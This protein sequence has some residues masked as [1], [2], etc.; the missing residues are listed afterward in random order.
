MACLGLWVGGV[1]G[2]ASSQSA[3]KGDISSVKAE[4]RI[5][6]GGLTADEIQSQVM[7]FADTYLAYVRQG[8]EELMRGGLTPEER[9]RAYRG[10]LNTVYGAVL[11]AS[12]PNSL[13]AMM[14]MV[15]LVTLGRMLTED[16]WIPDVFGDRALP[17][18]KTL[19][20]AEAE[21]W[22]LAK[23]VLW[24]EQ[25]QELHDIIA[26]WRVD[27][28]DQIVISTIRLSELSQY[29]R[30]TADAGGKQRS[31]V[32]SFFYVDPLAN[33]DPATRE[34]KR[35]RELTERVFYYS[36]R[37][38]LL[39]NWMM[40]SL[41]YDLAASAEMQQLMANTTQVADVSERFVAEIEGFPDV[42]ARERKAAITQMA[43]NITVEREAA[44][45]QFMAGIADE[46][47]AFMDDLQAEED[48]LRGA[49]ADLKLTIDA[50]T[51]LSS[52]LDITVASLDKFVAQFESD[53]DEP[54]GEPFDI[55]DYRQTA[56]ELTQAARQLDELV[57]SVDQLLVTARPGEDESSFMAAIEVAETSGARL[58]DVAFKRAL[59]IVAALV[60]G[61]VVV[62]LVWRLLPR[63]APR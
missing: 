56:I 54:R 16:Y 52:S 13:V 44:I 33:L 9:A 35:A 26:Q 27:H 57:A 31:S 42:I 3:A 11:I 30:K 50:G 61:S 43:G 41:Y 4:Q 46:R 23:L 7:G 53:P 17:V 21:I 2:C 12:G 20:T 34:I 48:R 40:R 38:P 45:D 14:D 55:N 22:E 6:P 36:E 37:V 47:K 24:P 28:P 10:Q 63:G 8:V 18:L 5:G 32:F 62:V 49:L 39:L 1:T 60:G 58:I 51:E 29:R 19:Q 15:V 25:Q 59:V